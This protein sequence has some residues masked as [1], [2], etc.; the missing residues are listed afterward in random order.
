MSSV[1]ICVFIYV[2]GEIIPNSSGNAIFTSDNTKSMLL[3]P[4]MT[5]TDIIS[6]I[7]SS[8]VDDDVSPAIIL[9]W[10]QCPKYEMNGHVEYMACRI[11]DEED[12]WCLFNTFA[13]MASVICME[14]RIEVHTSP[15]SSQAN[16]LIWTE[17]EQKLDNSM[18]LE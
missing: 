17:M 3:Y 6:V 18:K 5:L 12:V 11:I 15:S 10:Y 4:T 7:Q 9:L 13:N 8:I 16:D 1:P 14:L 2:N